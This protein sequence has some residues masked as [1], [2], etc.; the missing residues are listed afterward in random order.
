M[1]RRNGWS[2]WTHHWSLQKMAHVWKS[3]IRTESWICDGIHY[4]NGF[5]DRF[6]NCHNNDTIAS[7]MKGFSGV[8]F[9]TVTETIQIVTVIWPKVTHH[10]NNLSSQILCKKTIG[11]ESVMVIYPSQIC[12]CNEHFRHSC[13]IFLSHISLMIFYMDIIDNAFEFWQLR[14]YDNHIPLLN[15]LIFL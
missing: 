6:F 3:Q 4:W 2:R 9:V 8:H 12:F 10:I 11:K 15:V 14:F 5:S 7:S 1:P 13:F